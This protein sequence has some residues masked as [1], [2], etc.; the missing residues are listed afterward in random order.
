MRSER[1][2]A[3]GKKLLAAI[4]LAAAVVA[5]AHAPFARSALMSLGGCPFAGAHMTAVE[6]QS[7]RHLAL[8]VAHAEAAAP[9]RPAPGFAL[10]STARAEVEA[11]ATIGHL[12]CRKTRQ[13]LVT[14]V[15]VP[16]EALGLPSVEGSID[17]L[18]LQFDARDRLVDTTVLRGHL[19]AQA[20]AAV[21]R[22]VVSSLETRLGPAGRHAGTFD[23]AR[24]SHEGAE[25]I[26]TVM[27]RY[28]DYVADV[29]VMN[30]PAGGPSILEHY[31]SAKD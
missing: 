16:P 2:A 1:P 17:E 7:A 14:C 5:L 30:A 21:A 31:M 23:A 13:D 25:S 6:A 11:W 8:T 29:T 19:S 4:A 26:A 24:L 18:T 22:S 27:Y 3:R 28:S 10:D 15:G 9:A 20:A 12:E